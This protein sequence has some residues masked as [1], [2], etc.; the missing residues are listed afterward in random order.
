MSKNKNNTSAG[1]STTGVL[2]LRQHLRRAS[3]RSLCHSIEVLRVVFDEELLISVY[4]VLNFPP[5]VQKCV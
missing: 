3:N 4:D 1:V 5:S 2:A